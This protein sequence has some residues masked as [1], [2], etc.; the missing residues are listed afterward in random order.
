MLLKTRLRL[1]IVILVG[2]VVFL[3]SLVYL[4]D[5]TSTHLE[6]IHE[7]ASLAAEQIKTY[8]IERSRAVPSQ[9]G[10]TT[11]Q[12]KQLWAEY[13]AGESELAALLQASVG[14]E[15]SN[16]V[17]IVIIDERGLVVAT[18]GPSEVGS[19]A[20]RFPRLREWQQMK[21]WRQ[22]RELVSQTSEYYEVVVPLGIAGQTQP[23][24]VV[25]V[26]VS[27]AV[28]RSRLMP[29]LRRFGFISLASLVI[30]SIL[31]VAWSNLAFRPVVKI[32]QALD[33]ITGGDPSRE[34]PPPATVRADTEL[35]AVQSKIDLLGQQIRGAR[36]E[37]SQLRG[38]VEQLLERLEDGV[39]LFD[40]NNRLVMAGRAVERLIG[41][42]RWEA[43][44]QPLETVLPPDTPLGALVQTAVQIRRPIREHLLE[45]R[46]DGVPRQPLLVSV[47]SL[48]DLTGQDHF[49]AIVTIRDAE[50]RLQVESQLQVSQRLSAISR[51]TRGV[52]H[53]IKNPLN[54]ISVHLEIL[55]TEL[56]AEGVD[57]HDSA[58][59]IGR[60]LARLDRVVK[61]F[62]DFNRPLEL[63]MR[64]VDLVNLARD[65]AILVRPQAEQ[66]N[67]EVVLDLKAEK[68]PV[69]GDQDLLVQ[70]LLNVVTN[71]VEAMKQGGRLEVRLS[72]DEGDWVLEVADQGPGIP[73]E[74]REKIFELYFTTKKGGSGIGLAMTFRVIQLHNATI[75]F[76][77]EPGKGTTF[78]FR[79]P[80][81][82][83]PHDAA[84]S[85][86][87]ADFQS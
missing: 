76:T 49:G 78:V 24:F 84:A 87:A 53:E 25:Q 59:V 43:F 56:A 31:A 36:Q 42:S 65:A 18:S 46:R 27:S 38:N 61:T 60:E 39:L 14:A 83:D 3:L 67:I 81:L 22:L 52:A 70:A 30:A 57:S 19:A 17:E 74:V 15:E 47:E 72:R 9:P 13:I 41:I 29:Q 55:R 80:S 7:P 45:S 23:V 16:L 26:V 12:W 75:D 11:D 62:L 21:V 63:R 71:G 58:D 51:I 37:S 4:G 34:S 33:R 20:H 2:V 82:V 50:S 86:P 85:E 1:S 28:V 35:A 68:A 64:E 44:G 10:V 79:F 40:R 69:H 5:L 66:L 32:G 77:S 48:Q 8:L 6:R 73:P 54:A